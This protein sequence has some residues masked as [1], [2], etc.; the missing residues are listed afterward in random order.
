[1]APALIAL[2]SPLI[3]LVRRFIPDKDKQQE[4]ENEIVRVIASA[5]SKLGDAMLQDSRSE[6]RFNSGWRPALGWTGV[7][8][9]ALQVLIFP[10]AN[11]VLQANGRA[12]IVSTLST[13]VLWA[14]ITLMFGVGGTRTYEKLQRLK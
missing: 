6:S 11:M 5:D 1:M 14:V 8:G 3:D 13:E 12:E 9:F 4:A 2:A 7:V 10:L